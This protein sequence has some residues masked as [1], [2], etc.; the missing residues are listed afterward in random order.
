MFS[1]LPP[2]LEGPQRQLREAFSGGRPPHALLLLGAEGLGGELL[3]GWIAA[4]VLCVGEGSRPCGQCRS[5]VA[6]SRGGHPDLTWLTP[7]E[8]SKQIR[9]YE[10]RELIAYLALKSHQGGY[11]VVIVFPAESLNTSAANA[12]LKTL[13][14]PAPQTLLVLVAHRRARLPATIVSRCQRLVISAPTSAAAGEWLRR[15][16][17]DSDAPALLRFAR[18]APLRALDLAAREFGAI[19]RDMREAV[20]RLGRGAL[21]V[22]AAADSW[23]RAGKGRLA[24][25]VTWLETWVTEGIA[26]AL[27]A[28]ET[29]QTGASRG[30]PAA[31]ET[32]KIRGLYRVLDRLKQLRAA[33]TTS[34]NMTMA[35]ESLLLDL[36]QALGATAKRA[37]H[38]VGNK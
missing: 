27:G 18:G 19:D 1:A 21:D 35:V 6:I 9:I 7:L 2:W 25:R 33:S 22:P 23:T 17:P 12:L 16:M 15:Q 20:D 28:T 37:T 30:L 32:L 13:E 38:G 3:A 34:L 8:D 4:R 11:K 29:A 24:D 26:R 14:E 10:V 31:H 5:C 36:R